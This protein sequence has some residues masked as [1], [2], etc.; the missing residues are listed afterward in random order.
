MGG[1][2]YDLDLSL[3]V[4]YTQLNKYQFNNKPNKSIIQC[5]NLQEQN[6]AI[7]ISLFEVKKWFNEYYIFHLRSILKVAA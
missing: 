3:H 1:K 2:K 5:I 6:T 7:L 4:N